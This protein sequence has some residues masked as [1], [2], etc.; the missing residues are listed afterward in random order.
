MGV[1]KVCVCVRG[2]ACAYVYVAHFDFG[3]GRVQTFRL[4]LDKSV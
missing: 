4:P 3:T 1:G 2:V